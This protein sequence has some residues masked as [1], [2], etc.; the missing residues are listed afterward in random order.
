MQTYHKINSIYKR[1]RDGKQML[2]GEYSQPEFEYLK[3]NLWEFTEKVD[4]TNIRVIW[5]PQIPALGGDKLIPWVSFKG[6]TDNAQI[7]APLVEKLRNLFPVEKFEGLCE[8]C[9]YGEGYG[10]KIQNGGNYISDG[11]DFVLFDVLISNLTYD[12]IKTCPRHKQLINATLNDLILLEGFVSPAIIS[13]LKRKILSGQEVSEIDREN[14]IKLQEEKQL[15]NSLPEKTI[16]KQSLESAL[17]NMT[18]CLDSK[19]EFVQSAEKQISMKEEGEKLLHSPLTTTTK[20]EEL[21]DYFAQDVTL[22]LVKLKKIMSGLVKF[23]CTCETKGWWLKREDVNE[24]ANK[25]GIKAVPVVGVSTLEGLIAMCRHGFKSQ[26]GDFIAEG[27]VARPLYEL[28]DR[29]GHR[30]ITKLKH[31]DFQNV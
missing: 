9:L 2:F 14:I 23:P 5:E 31:K 16:S 3:D 17:K 19:T 10:A 27:I 1:S 4:G 22:Q 15:E 21:E 30:I 11:V 13:I 26:W 25:L 8:L 24:I 18:N 7:P 20:Q 6:K 29:A 12:K 28:R